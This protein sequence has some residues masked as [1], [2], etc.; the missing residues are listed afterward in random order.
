MFETIACSSKL[1]EPITMEGLA[2]EAD[3]DAAGTA[4]VAAAERGLRG[5]VDA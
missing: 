4:S 3:A 1:V 5:R 2:L